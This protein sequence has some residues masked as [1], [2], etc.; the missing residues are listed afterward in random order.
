MIGVI[1][2]NLGGP[3]SSKAVK[4]F[5]YNLFSDRDIIRLGPSFLQKTIASIIVNTRAKKTMK[6]YD[7]IGGRS[8]LLDITSA[9]AQALERVLNTSSAAKHPSGYFKIYVGMRYWHP[10]IE[11]AVDLTQKDD[12]SRVIALSLYPQYSVAT[13]G[14]SVKNFESAAKRYYID[15]L[16]VTSWF[17]HPGYIDAII[18]KIKEG[19]TGF[20]ERPA[21]L[22]SAHS[23]PRRLIDGGDPY[24][25]E[26]HGTIEAITKRIDIQWYLSYQSKTGQVKWLEP[27]TERMLSELAGKGIKNLLVVPVSFVSDHIETLYEIDIVYKDS[28]QRLGINLKRIASLN[29]SPDFIEALA[30]I[31]TKNAEER[32]W[33]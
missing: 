19:M 16:C 30:D 28:A 27:T 4:P 31:V 20:K 17:K 9:Q 29:T 15:Y 32:G 33:I 22:F 12:L 23:L 26:I 3:D 6:A 13:T 25:D 11:E 8:P 10:F 2:L 14:S 21:L 5:L 1:L 7:M 18:K 24:V